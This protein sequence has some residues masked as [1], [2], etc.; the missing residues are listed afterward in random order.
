MNA[1]SAL[2]IGAGIVGLSIARAL[3]VRGHR[4]TVLERFD[5]AVGASVRNFGMIW[6][7]GVPNGAAY[8]RAL[9]SRAIWQE[10]IEDARLWHDPCGSL[11]LAYAQDEW[12]VLEQYEHANRAL[13]PCSLLDREAALARSPALVG[14]G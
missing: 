12:E 5:R 9:R 1:P 7:I 6:P 13:R 2:V 11:H 14:E 3:A 4:V 8:E 10:L